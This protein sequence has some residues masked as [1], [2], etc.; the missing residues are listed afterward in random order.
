MTSYPNQ[1]VGVFVDVQNLYYSARAMYD[2]NVNF[3]QVLKV[4]V[5]NRQ[6]IRALAYVIK[7]EAPK[8]Q[9]FFEALEKA[10]YEIRSKDI[11]I[12]SDGQKKGDW[13]VGLSVDAIKMG[14]RLDVVI[15]VTGDGDYVPLVT[16]LKE[17]KGCRVEGAAFGRSTSAKLI[18]SLDGFIDLDADNRQYLMKGRHD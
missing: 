12:F 10:G 11:Q 16:Y 2:S 6:T 15:L 18:E 13:D 17:N 9:G 7:S 3:G 1:R 4:V 8:E 14:D 5:G